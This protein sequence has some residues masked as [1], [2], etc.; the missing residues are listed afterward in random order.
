MFHSKQSEQAF[1]ILILVLVLVLSYGA[2]VM[3]NHNNNVLKSP[4]MVYGA[5]IVLF[6][7]LSSALYYYKYK[8]MNYGDILLSAFLVVVMAMVVGA[9][10]RWPN[11]HRLSFL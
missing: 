8:N 10:M 11:R 7:L 4:M 5:T 9:S 1:N 3:M 6:V 2:V